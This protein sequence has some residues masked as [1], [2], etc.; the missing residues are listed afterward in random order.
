ML[1]L[2]FGQAQRRPLGKRG[3]TD[4]Q[5]LSVRCLGG[6]SLWRIVVPPWPTANPSSKIPSGLLH[7]PDVEVTSRSFARC[8]QEWRLDRVRPTLINNG[9]AVR[10]SRSSN[11]SSSIKPAHGSWRSVPRWHDSRA[12]VVGGVSIWSRSFDTG[13]SRALT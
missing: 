13:T 9:R 8:S 12:Q 11:G 10:A 7:A 5:E 2:T 1:R 6:R 3:Q 4:P